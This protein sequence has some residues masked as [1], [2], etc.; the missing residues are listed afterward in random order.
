MLK[1]LVVCY[2]DFMSILE[3]TGNAYVGEDCVSHFL[4]YMTKLADKT[5]DRLFGEPLK[6]IFTENDK[7][8]YESATE[9]KL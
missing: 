8:T 4:D 9:C 1:A 2:A 5:Y 3:K 6:M 7:E